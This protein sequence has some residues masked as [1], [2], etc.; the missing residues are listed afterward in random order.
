MNTFLEFISTLL[1]GVVKK[2]DTLSSSL[3]IRI[4]KIIIPVH[5]IETNGNYSGES[6]FVWLP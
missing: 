4:L 1:F 3:N 5:S 6:V 2:M